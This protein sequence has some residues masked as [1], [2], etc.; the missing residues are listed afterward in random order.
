MMDEGRK[1]GSRLVYPCAAGI[2]V[3]SG[4]VAWI[5]SIRRPARMGVSYEVR[6]DDNMFIET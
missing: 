1:R 6:R 4:Q 2:F 3:K 5:I